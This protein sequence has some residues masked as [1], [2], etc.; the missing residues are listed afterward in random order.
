VLTLLVVEV[1]T[2]NVEYASDLLWAFGAQAIEERAIG[3]VVELRTDFGE[4]P[5]E[6]WCDLIGT[7]PSAAAWSAR[8]DRVD[9]SVTE[10]WRDHVGVTT[11][12]EVRIVPAW[13]SNERKPGDVLIEPGGSFG[14]GDHPTTRATLTLALQ[15]PGS[16]VLDIGCGSGVL[17]IA[18]A[19]TRGCRVV[20]VDI[21]PAAIE[22]TLSNALRNGVDRLVLVETGDVRSVRGTYDLVLAN[23]L[24]PVLLADAADVASR[25]ATLGSV[26]LSGFTASRVNDIA[27]AY[28]ALGLVEVERLEVGGWFALQMQR[29]EQR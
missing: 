17:G 27:R 3:D 19:A 9:P 21:A 26:V 4:S 11:V 1:P 7:H 24:A 2:D 28:S 15:I 5:L 16:S 14:M 23:I 10:G 18:L 22:A 13:W 12:G 6:R 29:V 25:V 8:I 20:A